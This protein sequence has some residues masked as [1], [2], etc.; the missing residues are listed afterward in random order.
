MQAQEKTIFA[1]QILIID[2]HQSNADT[3]SEML[4]L[5]GFQ[6]IQTL[7]EPRKAITLIQDL[8][9]DLII[10]DL[11][12]PHINGL[13]LLEMMKCQRLIHDKNDVIMLTGDNDM[14]AKVKALGLGAS[15]FI[16]KPFSFLEVKTRIQ[17]LL[18]K[19]I[20]YTKLDNHNQLL[21]ERVKERTAALLHINDVILDQN[22]KL[23]KLTWMQSHVL[24]APL[25]R[26]LSI[27]NLL[28]IDKSLAKKEYTALLKN[29]IDAAHEVDQVIKD[30]SKLAWE[31]QL[32]EV[33]PES[34]DS[35]NKKESN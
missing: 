33:A 26:F 34:L 19:S 32:L 23:K 13:E 20:L 3:L 24:R 30:M 35:A 14:N 29:G 2:D 4:N 21:E 31:S 9:P 28:T 15:D 11:H 27:A 8:H 25:A 17:N 7:C 16:T 22:E 1:S 12:M 6:S 10:L 18:N 5:A